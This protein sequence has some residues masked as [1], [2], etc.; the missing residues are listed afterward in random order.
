VRAPFAP[1]RRRGADDRAP[2]D[3][4]VEGD[5][6]GS[7]GAASPAITAWLTPPPSLQ[8]AKTRRDNAPNACGLGAETAWELPGLQ[9]NV[10]GAVNCTPSTAT[11]SPAGTVS[12][13]VGN[14][15]SSFAK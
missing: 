8:E 13:V 1:P 15:R 10:A 3:E 7:D 5:G 12:I 14:V 2:V 6:G 9:E 4:E 11:F